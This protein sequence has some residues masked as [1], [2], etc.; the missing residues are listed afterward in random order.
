MKSIKYVSFLGVLFLLTLLLTIQTTMNDSDTFWHISLGQYMLE[1][2]SILREAIYTFSGN[3]LPYVPHEIGFQLL[4]AFLYNHFSWNGVYFLNIISALFLFFGLFHMVEISKKELGVKDNGRANLLIVVFLFFIANYEFY[5][6]F[7]SRPQ[8]LSTPI[9]V[10]FFVYLRRFQME[11]K[12]KYIFILG[13]L[14]IFLANVHAGV[15][16][17][18]FVFTVMTLI[19][20]LWKKKFKINHIFLFFT[21]TL[22]GLINA[23]GYHTLFYFY[24]LSNEKTS[25]L[26]WFPISFQDFK[27]YLLF[28]ILF[29]WLA[30]FSIHKSIFRSIFAL[31]IFYLGLQNYRSFMFIPIFIPYFLFPLADQPFMDKKHLLSNKKFIYISIIIIYLSTFVSNTFEKL[32]EPT[33]IYPVTEMNYILKHFEQN[34]RPNVLATYNS[35]GYVMFRGGNTFADG[36]FDPFITKESMKGNKK[37]DAFY[38]SANTLTNDLMFETIDLYHPDFI[39]LPK[40]TNPKKTTDNVMYRKTLKK[41]GKPDFTGKY[42]YVWRINKGGE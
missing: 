23:G 17:V 35:S 21:V 5:W 41:L 11:L 40:V 13:L 31:G 16:L 8:S 28:F 25:L 19:E 2:Q 37:W 10:W 9:I 32:K 3:H 38:R 12:T 26:E 36:R 24:T 6:Y 1:H 34:K 30:S 7:N 20:S 42:G 22:F 18:I 29:T 4:L 33:T 27:S 14:S 39:V 15:W